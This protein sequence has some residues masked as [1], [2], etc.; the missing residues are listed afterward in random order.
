MPHSAELLEEGRRY[1][2]HGVLD[3]ALENY[4]RAAEE[5]ADPSIV[6]EAL[7]HQSRVHRCRSMALG[8]NAHIERALARHVRLFATF[9]ANLLTLA[10]KCEASAT[11]IRKSRKIT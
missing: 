6:V 7:T 9:G 8:S 4:V 5:T 11:A 1:E 3:R 10:Q 2:G